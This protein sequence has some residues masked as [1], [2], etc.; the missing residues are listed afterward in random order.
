MRASQCGVFACYR[1]QALEYKLI[2][3]AAWAWL[4]GGMW[5]LPRPEIE[6]VSAVLAGGFVTTEPPGEDC[7]S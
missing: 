5:D 7:L 3:C 2:N 4:P 6:P 1:A